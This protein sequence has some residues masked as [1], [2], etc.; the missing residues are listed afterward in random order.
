MRASDGFSLDKRVFKRLLLCCLCWCCMGMVAHAQEGGAAMPAGSMAAV[1]DSATNAAAQDKAAVQVDRD[2]AAQRE[3][4]KKALTVPLTLELIGIDIE[5][6]GIYRLQLGFQPGATPLPAFEQSLRTDCGGEIEVFLDGKLHKR[7]RYEDHAGFAPTPVGNGYGP[8]YYV[9][10][11]VD[12][13]GGSRQCD[14]YPK[15]RAKKPC[16]Y[17]LAISR[18]HYSLVEKIGNLFRSP[19]DNDTAAPETPALPRPELEAQALVERIDILTA[20]KGSHGFGIGVY[21]PEK[22][23]D[24][25]QSRLRIDFAGITEVWRDG[26][27]YTSIDYDDTIGVSYIGHNNS[28]KGLDY[29]LEDIDIGWY[30]FVPKIV[31]FKEGVFGFEFGRSYTSM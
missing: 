2:R 21:K 31:S 4:R 22:Q 27:K 24:N 18:E 23:E 25:S 5:K 14:L 8:V 12:F 11:D 13:F 26:R 1:R 20:K 28:F 7:L 15:I 19:I 3:E 30:S 17:A 10:I 29:F 9:K 16:S 6:G